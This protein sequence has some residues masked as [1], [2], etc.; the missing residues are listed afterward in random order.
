MLIDFDAKRPATVILTIAGS[1][2][3]AGAGIQ[4]DLKTGAAFGVYVA[5]AITAITAQTATGPAEVFPVTPEQLERQIS[6]VMT[7]LPVAAVKIGMLANPALLAVVAAWLR[8]FEIPVVLD[9]VF[10]ATSGGA[11]FEGREAEALYRQQLIP[12]VTL[13]TPNLAEAGRLLEQAPAQNYE[14][15]V[16]QV[17]ALKQLGSQAVLL[18]GGH[19]TL[20]L[21]TDCLLA[22]EELTPYS[23]PRQTALHSHGSGCTL[24]TAIT[25]GLAQGLTLPQA[26]AA[27]KSFIQGAIRHGERLQLVPKNGPVHQFY[28]YW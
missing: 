27:A 19:N 23:A 20:P 17:Y 6:T 3:T 25:A 7:T 11:L 26:V 8:R 22:E 15:M 1:D 10:G 18:K 14:Q 2:N 28:Q 13:I 4:A 21:A 9:P 12:H 16:A 5:T 24:A